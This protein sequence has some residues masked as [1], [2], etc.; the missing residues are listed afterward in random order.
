[1]VAADHGGLP[2]ILR[3]GETGVLVRP[4]D[5]EA[6]ATALAA[7]A[8]DPARRRALGEAAAG[9]VRARFS[10]ERMLAELQ[11]RYDALVAG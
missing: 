5:P 7:L 6:L 1:V 8:D 10:T 2:E 11:G 4:N 9:D 3:D